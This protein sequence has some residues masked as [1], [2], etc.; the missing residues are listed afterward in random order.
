MAVAFIAFLKCIRPQQNGHYSI[1]LHGLIRPGELPASPAGLSLN[2]L[3]ILSGEKTRKGQQ[4][5][6]LATLAWV[7]LPSQKSCPN[8]DIGEGK[9]D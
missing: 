3:K 8:K 1:H 9:R 5:S 7:Y 2:E 6:S 4:I